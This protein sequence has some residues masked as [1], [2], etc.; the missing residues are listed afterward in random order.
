MDQRKSKNGN[1]SDRLG[2]RS[3]EKLRLANKIR[4]MDDNRWAR[5]YFE[6]VNDIAQTV[7]ES[8][9]EA[10][11]W[12]TMKNNQKCQA[13]RTKVMTDLSRELVKEV[14]ALTPPV[15]AP[16][17]SAP[18]SASSQPAGSTGAPVTAPTGYYHI[19]P[20]VT[21]H[22]DIPSTT[23]VTDVHGCALPA[24]PT[25]FTQAAM[26]SHVSV[27][28]FNEDIVEFSEF[29]ETVESVFNGLD[30]ISKYAMLLSA[31][32]KEHKRLIS[33]LRQ[34]ATIK[35]HSITWRPTATGDLPTVLQYAPHAKTSVRVST[36]SC[37]GPSVSTTITQPVF[38]YRSSCAKQ[39]VPCCYCDEDLWAIDSPVLPFV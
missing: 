7:N 26:A 8:G 9:V 19:P 2:G 22:S 11:E 12:N 32:G 5:R 33:G 36:D 1:R 23:T 38:N 34:V 31:L 24:T 20:A 3:Y 18:S 30:D 35:H 15:A 39:S 13:N 21:S 4:N 16:R 6:G 10:D 17:R 27:P 25:L 14:L 29:L 28:R 37:R